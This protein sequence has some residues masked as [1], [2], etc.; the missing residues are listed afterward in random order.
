MRP[1][2][3]T[4]LYCAKAGDETP[5]QSNPLTNALTT[6]R[7]IFNSLSPLGYSTHALVTQQGV[8]ARFAAPEGLEVLHGRTAAARF[9]DGLAVAT[10]DF[11]AQHPGFGGRGFLESGVRIRREY[12]SPL[13]A[14]I[15]CRVA[16]GKDV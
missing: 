13:V 15:A 6:T 1:S 2:G 7:F 9:E 12:L 16:A 14:V 3:P 11:G 10:T 8:D 4:T 5:A